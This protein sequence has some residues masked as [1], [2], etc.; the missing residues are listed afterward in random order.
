MSD[1]E[2]EPLPNTFQRAPVSP[3]LVR[4]G[5]Y[6]RTSANAALDWAL[7][8]QAD[9]VPGVSAVEVREG[10]HLLQVPLTPESPDDP[11]GFMLIHRD[12]V[13]D[14]LPHVQPT[15]QQPGGVIE[16]PFSVTHVVPGEAA[17]SWRRSTI[18]LPT[19]GYPELLSAY[20]QE[21]VVPPGMTIYKPLEGYGAGAATPD[22]VTGVQSVLAEQ[23]TAYGFPPELFETK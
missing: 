11:G 17:N 14:S 1:F 15:P 4:A 5:D 8:H 10:M 12:T 2:H 23:A 13:L 18:V 19:D 7:S 21:K 20:E 3:E 6:L 9:L 22:Q 16:T